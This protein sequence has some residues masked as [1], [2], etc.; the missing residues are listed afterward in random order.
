MIVVGG[1]PVGLTLA[2]GL[3]RYGV[4]SIVLERNASV[5]P[6]SRSLVVWPRTIEVLRMW[7]LWEP[8]RSAGLF[9]QTLGVY[10]ASSNAALLSIDFGVLDDVLDDPG[11]LTIPQY[12]VER[13]L[14]ELVAAD[15]LCDFRVSVSAT[16]VEQHGDGATVTTRTDDGHEGAVRGAYVVGCD[17]AK[18]IVRDEIGITLE[19]MTYDGRILLGDEL[20]DVDLP[21]PRL[22]LDAPSPLG[23]WKY[24]GDRWRIM[25]FIPKNADENVATT[26]AARA[27]RLRLLFGDAGK[28]A[29][30][31]WQNVSRFNRRHARRFAADRVLLAGDAAH[32]NGLAGGQGLNAGIQ[33]VANLAWKLA[34]VFAG[35]NAAA[36]IESYHSERHEMIEDFIERFAE[37]TTRSASG[38][39]RRI[40]RLGLGLLSRSVRARG[41]QCKLARGLGMLNGRYSKSTIVDPR[42]PVAGRRVGDLLLS[43]GRRINAVRGLGAAVVAIADADVGEIAAIRV[44]AVPKRWHIKLPAALIVRP[45]G[46]VAAVIDKPTPE[47]VSIAWQRAFVGGVPEPVLIRSS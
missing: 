11:Y 5:A 6:E 13:V 39:S 27:E 29:R 46:Y 37:R 16:H 31:L 19:G 22:A 3:S 25:A 9:S 44:D 41:L 1:G 15:P 35:G 26:D 32:A 8:I 24:A 43:D 20:L 40:R 42:H 21:S 33:D 12:E 7:N 2:L 30:L 4:R 34:A 36:L 45:D 10:K 47:K 28:D 14:R 17:G 18:G 23:A 38:I